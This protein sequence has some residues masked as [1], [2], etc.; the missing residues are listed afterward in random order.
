MIDVDRAS[1]DRVLPAASG[2]ADWADVLSRSHRHQRRRRLVVVVAAAALVV[3]GAASALAARA[4]L[5]EPFIGLPP[6]GAT[7][8]TPESGELVLH[9][10]G[11]NPGVHGKSRIWLYADGRLISLRDADL[12]EGANPLST[13]FLEQRLTPAGAELLRSEV[14]STGLLAPPGSVTLPPGDNHTQ[15]EVRDGD[16]LVRV[17]RASD[18]DRLIARIT[19]PASWL[20]ASAWEHQ[21]FRAYVPSRF[22]V[23]FGGWETAAQIEP[24]SISSLLPGPAW[25][26]L[27]TRDR[28]RIGPFFG[29]A[30]ASHPIYEYCSD[31]TTAEARA[32]AAAL[33]DAGIERTSGYRLSYLLGADANGDMAQL[34]FEP[35]LP[36]GEIT[37][38]ACG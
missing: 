24:S 19:N 35:Y 1:M 29:A 14:V 22:A 23:C 5:D 33:D 21:G 20:P 26:L 36:H 11:A 18:P 13:G 34:Y 27:R 6:E 16:R 12:P 31:M 4:F 37:C 25:D 9:Y 8:S 10:F 32:L 30:G 7:P 15:I 3:L 38:S 2:A 17:E 28:T